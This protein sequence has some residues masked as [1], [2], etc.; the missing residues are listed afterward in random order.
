MFD[1]TLPGSRYATPAT[2]A[3]PNRATMGDDTER[4]AITLETPQCIG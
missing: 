1:A 3:G 2:I 4:V